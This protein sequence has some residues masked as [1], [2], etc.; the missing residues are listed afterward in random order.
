MPQAAELNGRRLNLVP[1]R[2]VAGDRVD[3]A[4]AQTLDDGAAVASLRS[5]GDSFAKVR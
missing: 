5:G 4:V 3:R 1:R 2:M